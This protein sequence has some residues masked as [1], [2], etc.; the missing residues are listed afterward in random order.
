VRFEDLFSDETHVQQAELARLLSTLELEGADNLNWF[1]TTKPV[2]AS[3]A[4]VPRNQPEESLVKQICGPL[5]KQWN[6][7]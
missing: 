3:P 5:L 6:Y 4:S 1:N 7:E 2:N